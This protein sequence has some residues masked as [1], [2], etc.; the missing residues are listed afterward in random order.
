MIND[1]DFLK[2]QGKVNALIS[3]LSEKERNY[4]DAEKIKNFID[5]YAVL[6]SL[7][8]DNGT[9]DF[10][11]QV[12]AEK[13]RFDEVSSKIDGL[14]SVIDIESNKIVSQLGGGQSSVALGLADMS[15]FQA[16]VSDSYSSMV[17]HL[18]EIDINGK[19]NRMESAVSQSLGLVDELRQQKAQLDVVLQKI[20]ENRAILDNMDSVNDEQQRLIEDTENMIAELE[21]QIENYAFY[22]EEFDKIYTTAVAFTRSFSSLMSTVTYL[23]SRDAKLTALMNSVISLSSQDFIEME[24]IVSG[25]KTAMSNLAYNTAQKIEDSMMFINEYNA[26]GL[27]VESVSNRS[28]NVLNSCSEELDALTQEGIGYGA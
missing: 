19:M 12:V 2:L 25:I 3:V 10:I 9:L 1:S 21:K 8:E 14:L 16:S 5:N 27:A 7:I 26:V 28:K 13:R 23:S 20:A 18:A 17:E 22:S 15:M 24:N 4:A 11:D 6:I